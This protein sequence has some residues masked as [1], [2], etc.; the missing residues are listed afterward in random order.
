[1]YDFS[2]NPLKLNRAVSNAR[3]A[4]GRSE[5]SEEEVKAEYVKIGGLLSKESINKKPMSDEI[6]PEAVKEEV[7]EPKEEVQPEVVVEPA[8]EVV[9]DDAEV[10][11]ESVE[12]EAPVESPVA[13]SVSESVDDVA[14]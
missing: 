10:S 2:T 7:A 13:E 6:K 4:L 14:L 5:V 11:K 8:P 12:V 1:M 9:A 3:F